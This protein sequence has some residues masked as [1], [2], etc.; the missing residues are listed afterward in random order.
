MFTFA[1]TSPTMQRSHRLSLLV[2]ASI[3][4]AIAVQAQDGQPASELYRKLKALP[5]VVEV[6][7]T[8]SRGNRGNRG[9]GAFKEN[10]TII[11]EQ[12]VD[13][14]NASGQKFRQKVYLSH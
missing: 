2:S 9:G 8:A 12:L 10:Y 13:H 4:F 6:T 14:Q 5:G 11:F 7:P 1:P 3:L